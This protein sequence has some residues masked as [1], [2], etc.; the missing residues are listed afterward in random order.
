[1]GGGRFP[2]PRRS[3][4]R[5]RATGT[6]SRCTR[7]SSRRPGPDRRRDVVGPLRG[8][9]A[10]RELPG[11][12]PRDLV[13]DEL[14]RHRGRTD[15]LVR[16]SRRRMRRP[17][18]DRAWSRSA[19]RRSSTPRRSRSNTTVQ[20]QGS[21][22]SPASFLGYY[23]S[24]DPTW[25]TTTSRSTRP[26][27]SAR[28]IRVRARRSTRRCPP[29]DQLHDGHVHHRLRRRP[30]QIDEITQTNNCAATSRIFTVDG[31]CRR[32]RPTR[33]STS[34]SSSHPARGLRARK[35]FTVTETVKAR[36][37]QDREA[38]RPRVAYSLFA[39]RPGPTTTR[40]RS[41]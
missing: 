39:R 41:P 12:V 8:S 27:P 4:S 22:T 9:A 2:T 31:R 25:T 13:H 11:H 21:K 18:R 38:S 10:V 17:R 30:R 19:A 37:R 1:M 14:G 16:R 7:S 32:N 34:R 26:A 40:R 5:T 29:G 24:G 6:G 23:F 15:G 3:R 35:S 33:T 36:R 20:N 28:S